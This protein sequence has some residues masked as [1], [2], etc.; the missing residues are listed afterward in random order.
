MEDFGVAITQEDKVIVLKVF[1]DNEEG[2]ECVVH[3]H[4]IYPK[5][6]ERSIIF[7]ISECD[8]TDTLVAEV[9]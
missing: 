2:V 3:K 1:I 5:N 6:D 9:E 4:V 8:E 7:Q